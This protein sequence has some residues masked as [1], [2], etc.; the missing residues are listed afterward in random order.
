MSRNAHTQTHTH[1]HTRIYIYIVHRTTPS[2]SLH[3][4][5]NKCVHCEEYSSNTRKRVTVTI[6]RVCRGNALPPLSCYIFHN[7]KCMHAENHNKNTMK[8][9]TV[10]MKHVR[11]GNLLTLFY[12]TL[13]AIMMR[14]ACAVGSVA[15]THVHTQTHTHPH[16]RIYIYI[17]HRTTP[18]LSLHI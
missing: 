18:S 16:T 3:I 12:A 1:P 5:S 8:S 15:R 9:V 14:S 2:L 10:T 17:V 13:F 7:E 11:C 6:R 4:S